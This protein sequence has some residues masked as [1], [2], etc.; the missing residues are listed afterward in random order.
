MSEGHTITEVGG[1]GDVSV[2]ATSADGLIFHLIGT[3]CN[4]EYSEDC[5][6]LMVQVRYDDDDDV[7][8]GAINNANLSYAAVSTWWDKEGDTVGVT[9]YLI[10]DGW[11]ADGKPEDKPAERARAWSTDRGRHLAR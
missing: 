9:R 7:T 3:A 11:P 4:S 2:R 5:L 1:E 6:G 8:E 10:L